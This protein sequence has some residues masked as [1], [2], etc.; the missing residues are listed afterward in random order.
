MVNKSK[1]PKLHFKGFGFGKKNSSG[2]KAGTKGV[3]KQYMQ[4][5]G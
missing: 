3:A 1:K 4:P 2:S 5:K